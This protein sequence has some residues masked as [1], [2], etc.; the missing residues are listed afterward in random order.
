[1]WKSNSRI[2]YNSLPGLSRASELPPAFA[3]GDG[4]GGTTEMSSQ[5]SPS[6][7]T[8]GECG[9]RVVERVLNRKGLDQ[10]DMPTALAL[11]TA[12]NTVGRIR[13]ARVQSLRARAMRTRA[14]G[15]GPLLNSRRSAILRQ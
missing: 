1:M 12:P 14:R 4:V 11:R 13:D 2:Q 3:R 6:A 7:V 8:R 5:L 9:L 15:L 10:S